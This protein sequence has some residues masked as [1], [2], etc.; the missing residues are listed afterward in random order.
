MVTAAVFAALLALAV[1]LC[2]VAIELGMLRDF[3]GRRMSQRE[4]ERLEAVRDAHE[5][6]LRSQKEGGARRERPDCIRDCCGDR[7]YPGRKG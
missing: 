3:A 2:G 6:A 7:A 5:D 1:V 4:Y